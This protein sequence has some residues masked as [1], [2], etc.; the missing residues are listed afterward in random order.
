VLVGRA[1]AG[2]CPPVATAAAERWRPWRSARPAG[3]SAW[4]QR[5]EARRPPARLRAPFFE[6]GA[7]PLLFLLRIRLT[8][9]EP[10]QGGACE[11]TRPGS[12]RSFH[13]CSLPLSLFVRACWTPSPCTV[14]RCFSACCRIPFHTPSAAIPHVCDAPGHP[15]RVARRRRALQTALQ[16]LGRRPTGATSFVV[17]QS[18]RK[19]MNTP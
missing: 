19:D 7:I 11:P 4:G 13:P 8:P 2:G 16:Q 15:R 3:A 12:Q 18:S 1:W 14:A 5:A 6:L 17:A 10:V 9:L